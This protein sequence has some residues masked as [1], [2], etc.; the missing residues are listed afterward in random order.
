MAGAG[1]SQPDAATVLKQMQQMQESLGVSL[2]HIEAAIA[3]REKRYL[4]DAQQAGNLVH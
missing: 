1:G 4:D 2:G 3:Q